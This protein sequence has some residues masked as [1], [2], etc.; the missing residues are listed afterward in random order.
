MLITYT[1]VFVI[2]LHSCR[3]DAVAQSNLLPINK[4][5]YRTEIAGHWAFNSVEWTEFM[6]SWLH[7]FIRTSIKAYIILSSI[8]AYIILIIIG[9][10]FQRQTHNWF[11][12]YVSIPPLNA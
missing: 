9:M 6:N 3:F 10:P 4:E 7:N 12:F 11:E 1:G 5:E 2:H 8:L